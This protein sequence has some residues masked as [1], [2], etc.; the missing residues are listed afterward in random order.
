MTFSQKTRKNRK[1]IR[2]TRKLI[3]TRTYYTHHNGSRPYLVQVQGTNVSISTY[4]KDLPF[5]TD[6]K[7]V[8]Y[9]VPV[10]KYKGVQNVFIGKSIPGDDMY[11]SYPKNPKK[12][13]KEGRG[14]SIL[15][16][17]GKTTY[18]FIGHKVIEFT[19][20][21]PI[22][23]YYSMIGNNDVPYPV[24]L[25]DKN[26]YF[27][28]SKEMISYVPREKFQG[29]PKTYNW[30]LNAYDKLWGMS[31]FR[32]KEPANVFEKVLETQKEIHSVL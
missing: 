24:V 8:H 29:F 32:E 31:D 20:K 10:K 1:R 11:A 13:E 4:P 9:T 30:G 25:S 12:A 26:V 15:L 5:D 6:I 22:K 21:E 27:V 18:V 2:K 3:K 28:V 14:N 23:K 7:K 19:T 16:H 17:L